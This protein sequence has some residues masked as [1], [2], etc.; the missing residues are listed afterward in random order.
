MMPVSTR[1]FYTV[2][3]SRRKVEELIALL[4]VGDIE[5]LVDVRAVPRSRTNPWFNRDTLPDTLAPFGIGYTHCPALGGMRERSATI[6]TET[7]DYWHNPSFHNY[8]DYALSASFRQA[9]A[10]LIELGQH[11]TCAIMCAEAV[12]WR[13][14][15]RIIADHLIHHG[16]TVY[17]L[18]SENRIEPATMTSAA[19]HRADGALIYP[20]D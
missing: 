4:R 7:N 20:A 9:I 5:Q 6:D 15:R 14:H 19:R 18:M 3:H 8:A 12:W 11:R 10:A 13:C 17:H 1:P 2:G 16:A